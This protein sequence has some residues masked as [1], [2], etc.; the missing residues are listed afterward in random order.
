MSRL[1]IR[2]RLIVPF[3]AAIAV[4]LTAMGFFVYVRV[5]DALLASVDQSLRAQAEEARSHVERGRGLVDRDVAGGVTLAE[6][7]RSDGSVAEAEPANLPALAS[8]SERGRAL[9]G[10]S[11]RWNTR[12]PGFSGK[13]RVLAV[14]VSHGN[15]PVVLVAARTLGPRA[16][17]LDRLEHELLFGGAAALVLALLAGYGLGAS[18]LR[19]VEAMRVRAAAITAST[20]GQRLPVPRPRDE[21]SRLAETLNLMVARLEG[22][23]EHERRFVEDASHELRTPLALLRAEL[24]IALRHPRSR[25]ELEQALQ[26]ASEE[27]ERLI[28]LAEDLLLIAR[29]DQGAL[30]IRRERVSAR[31]VLHRAATRFA[32]IAGDRGRSVSVVEDDDAAVDVDLNRIEQAIGNL[33]DNALRYGAGDVRLFVRRANGQVELHV[34]DEGPGFSPAFLSRAFDRFSRAD[35]ARAAG[36]AGLGLAIVELIAQAHGGSASVTNDAR[37]ADTWITLEAAG[38]QPDSTQPQ[39]AHAASGA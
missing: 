21:L 20:R 25:A 39:P 3:A 24:E 12:I 17:A 10:R 8:A 5:S 7:V 29:S 32:T 18:A 16:E 6:L 28:R 35:E 4:V 15:R 38:E 36:G 27:T 22:A 13:W 14:R 34:A 2:L 19:P 37:G 33:V 30:P 26:S 31:D 9:A 23:L 1:P 11:V